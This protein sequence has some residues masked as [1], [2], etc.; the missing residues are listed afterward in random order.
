MSFFILC[1]N[2]LPLALSL[3][4]LGLFFFF[5]QCLAKLSCPPKTLL[6]VLNSMPRKARFNI[7][8]RISWDLSCIV[9]N[10]DTVRSLVNDLDGPFHHAFN[11]TSS[12]RTLARSMTLA[13]VRCAEWDETFHHSKYSLFVI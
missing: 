7:V 13:Q 4:L 12:N 8:K 10:N 2:V 3:S 6:A 9:M 1:R 5:L 11:P